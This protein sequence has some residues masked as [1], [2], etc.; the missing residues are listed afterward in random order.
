MLIT[1]RINFTQSRFYPADESSTPMMYPST[2]SRLFP[3][4]TPASTI[5]AYPKSVRLKDM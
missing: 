2:Y 3:K 1:I 4:T 5:G